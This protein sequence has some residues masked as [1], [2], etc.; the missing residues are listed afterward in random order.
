[1]YGSSSGPPRCL[2]SRYLS[3]L[4]SIYGHVTRP[5]NFMK[6]LLKFYSF[7][8]YISYKP[9]Y[10]KYCWSCVQ[11]LVWVPPDKCWESTLK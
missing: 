7:Q 6:F 10:G 8:F 4:H 11:T 9:L 3:V 2:D 1:L 5:A